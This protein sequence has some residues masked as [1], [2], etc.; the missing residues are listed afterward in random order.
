MGNRNVK[1][2]KQGNIASYQREMLRNNI[3]LLQQKQIPESWPELIVQKPLAIKE[4]VIGYCGYCLLAYDWIQ[5]LAQWIGNRPCL[6]IMC[7]SGSLSKGLQN[8]G[9]KVQATDDHS[10]MKNHAISWFVDSWTEIEQQNAVA[11][12][13][14]YGQKVDFV[15]CSWPFSSE[16]CYQA[17]LKMRETN[18]TARMI[19]IGEWRSGANASDSFFNAAEFVED[20]SFVQAVQRFKSLCGNSD[21]LYLLK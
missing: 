9:V 7:G 8:C 12:I 2:E 3:A 17:L 14:K 13:E 11:A 6:E 4:E 21:K 19:Y 15:I 16:D 1:K 18:P 5:P 20:E 10:W